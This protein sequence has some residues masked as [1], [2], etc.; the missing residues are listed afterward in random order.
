MSEKSR[1]KRTNV[2]GE[3]P[4]LKIQVVVSVNLSGA[5]PREKKKTVKKGNTW[6]ETC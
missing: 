6:G 1:T 5:T 4:K 3:R 2:K